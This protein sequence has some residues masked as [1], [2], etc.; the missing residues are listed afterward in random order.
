MKPSPGR[1]RL[2]TTA[3]YPATNAVVEVTD[4]A[5]RTTFGDFAWYEAG[6]CFVLGNMGVECTG[7][8][9]FIATWGNQN[10]AGTCV[11]L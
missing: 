4:A 7:T 5:L 9:T 8:G 6:G 1:Y 11:A 10:F 3:P 2:T